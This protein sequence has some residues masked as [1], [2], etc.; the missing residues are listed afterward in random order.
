MARM[1]GEEAN[2]RP[3]NPRVILALVGAAL[4]TFAVFMVLLAYAPNLSK[5]RD[6]RA[7]SLSVSA[8]GYA[9]LIKLLRETGHNPRLIR[10]RDELDTEDLLVAAVEPN[11][12][13]EAVRALL[14]ARGPRTTLLILPKWAAMPHQQR[15]GWV[16]RMGPLPAAVVEAGLKELDDV[17]VGRSPRHAALA[18]GTDLL[19][20]F[21]APLPETLQTISGNKIA[22]VLAGPGNSSIIGHLGDYQHYI[23]ADAD[24]VSNHG[25]KDPATAK[26]ALDLIAMLSTTD[27]EGVAFDL[28]LNG[29]AS[30]QNGL[31]MA[32][33]PPF[34]ALT[35]ALV[36]AA[37]LAGLHGLFRFGPEAREQRA[38]AFGKAALVE[39][40]AGLFRIARREHKTGRVYAEL[41]RDSAAQAT[42]AHGLRG[43]VLDAYLDRL[44]GDQRPP[45][46]RLASDAG[47]A[48][49]RHELLAAARTLFQWKKDILQ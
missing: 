16:Y 28:T 33:E 26:A 42:A 34:L 14:D 49:N 35:V 9:G 37:L 41:I 20:G 4:L 1:S 45:F 43:E 40:S 22:P 10:N 48:G 39:N 21:S 46:T 31:R 36:A 24:L 30:S 29:F 7:H 44:G 47:R 38:I 18:K 27:A 25:L 23:L 32:F 15:A 19:A 13:P 11:T 3:F 12:K 8:V 6:G 5:G 17:R 2:A